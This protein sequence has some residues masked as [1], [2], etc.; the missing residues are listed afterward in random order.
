MAT[1]ALVIISDGI[2]ELEAVAPIDCLRRAGVGV[3]V[4]SASSSLTVTGRNQ[5]KIGADVML[6]SCS[7][8]YSLIVIP[9]GPSHVSM[10]E[11]SRILDMLR[12]QEKA[13]KLI[14]SICAG[15]VVLKKAGILEGKSFTSFP[16][17]KDILPERDPQSEV[18]RDGNLITSQGAGTAVAFALALV[19]A[20]CGESAAKSIG[21]SICYQH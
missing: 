17:T 10:L 3:T 6:D 4:A 1:T 7:G 5:I 15:P 19:K 16:G 20:T 18:V 14:G 21:D 9:G 2:E 13:G 12:S 8:D 11:D